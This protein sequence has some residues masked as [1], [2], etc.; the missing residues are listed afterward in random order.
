MVTK[1]KLTSGMLNS[2]KGEDFREVAEGFFVRRI[3]TGHLP[4]VGR[5]RDKLIVEDPCVDQRKD[6]QW[7]NSLLLR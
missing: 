3:V 5:R 1:S 4:E 7:L 2:H 6:R